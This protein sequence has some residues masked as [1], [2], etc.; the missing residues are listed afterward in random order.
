MKNMN[1]KILKLSK[2]LLFP[3]I[4]LAPTTSLCASVPYPS[5]NVKAD[6]IKELDERLWPAGNKDI[7]HPTQKQSRIK[8]K[9]SIKRK[10]KK[11]SFD[12]GIDNRIDNGIDDNGIKPI[13]D[14]VGIRYIYNFLGDESLYEAI[15]HIRTKLKDSICIEDD[16]YV[17]FPK[18]NGYRAYHIHLYLCE[19]FVE[20]QILTDFM[21]NYNVNGPPKLYYLNRN[22]SSAVN[23]F[24]LS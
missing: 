13:Y 12:I 6:I 22:Q 24:S 23:V 18:E 1:F 8:T 19:T 2:L 16:D 17:K 4:L 20:I 21:Y 11:R 14:M 3:F 7:F 15:T 9:E 10:M 5:L